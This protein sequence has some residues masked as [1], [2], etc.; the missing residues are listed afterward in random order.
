[1]HSKRFLFH[2]IYQS[3]DTTYTITAKRH[4]QQKHVS[5]VRGPEINFR[6][7]ISQICPTFHSSDVLQIS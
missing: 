5:D 4:R 1:M 3:N 6:L 2:V 7:D